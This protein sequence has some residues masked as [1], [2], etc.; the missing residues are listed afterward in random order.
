MLAIAISILPELW[1][2]DTE[3]PHILQSGALKRTYMTFAKEKAR[4]Q[5]AKVMNAVGGCS[6]CFPLLQPPIPVLEQR[7][8]KK[9]LLSIAS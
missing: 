6:I 9:L 7:L 8:I 1:K 4:C 2:P 3:A 5:T